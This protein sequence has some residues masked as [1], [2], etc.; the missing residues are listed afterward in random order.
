MSL[1][2]NTTPSIPSIPST[3]DKVESLT[4]IV[5]SMPADDQQIAL[6]MID[7]MKVGIYTVDY[8]RGNMLESINFIWDG[9]LRSAITR[10][11]QYCERM[12]YR[13]L[14]CSPF[15]RN[16]RLDEERMSEKF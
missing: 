16:L 4:D 7:I 11:Q 14:H 5:K 6:R 13:F 9:D 8:R 10:A 2:A 12:R 15:L 1:V 3:L